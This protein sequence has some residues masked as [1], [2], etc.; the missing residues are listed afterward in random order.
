[1]SYSMLKNSPNC[2]SHQ[3]HLRRRIHVASKLEKLASGDCETLT[4]IKIRE[5]LALTL[6]LDYESGAACH[7]HQL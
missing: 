6:L 5:H 7:G 3:P 4:L 2:P 1:M